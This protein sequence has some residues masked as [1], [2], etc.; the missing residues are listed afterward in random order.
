MSTT[1]TVFCL[2]YDVP[3][4][5]FLSGDVNKELSMGHELWEKFG[6]M[7]DMLNTNCFWYVLRKQLVL[8]TKVDT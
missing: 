5:M 7:K 4:L 3:K 1:E 6:D 8:W 2:R